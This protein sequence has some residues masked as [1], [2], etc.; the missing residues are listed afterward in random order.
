[1]RS[2]RT[3]TLISLLLSGALLTGCSG[4]LAGP[5]EDS[6]HPPSLA[7]ASPS[8][9]A[10]SFARP[11]DAAR[12]IPAV[13]DAMALLEEDERPWVITVI[14]D[15]TGNEPDEWVFV[16]VN[17]L[18]KRYDRPV[19]VHRWDIKTNT[20]TDE[21]TVSS[22]ANAPIILWNGSA[23]GKDGL[24]SAS[25]F[26]TMAPEKPDLAIINHGHNMRTAAAALQQIRDLKQ[27]L[28]DAWD[29]APALAVTIQ[30]PRT[31]AGKAKM[32]DLSARIK[33]EW[34]GS[35]VQIL[36]VQSAFESSGNISKL[37]TKDGYHPSDA[38]HLLWAESVLETITPPGG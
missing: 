34:E 25:H 20:Y 33:D 26:P 16:V 3:P 9:S 38:G 31:D 30:N 28:V 11:S 24:Y 8:A 15:S 27:R 22:G 23:S 37:L 4:T 10:S 2:T 13:G 21:S 1:M 19:T 29:Q 5:S 35:S 18:A 6:S 32:K 12:T 17:E 14:G 7:E 36:D